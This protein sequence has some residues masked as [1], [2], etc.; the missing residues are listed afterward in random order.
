MARGKIRPH[1]AGRVDRGS[2]FRAP[3]PMSSQELG[4][5]SGPYIDPKT[6]KRVSPQKDDVVKERM[7]NYGIS[8]AEALGQINKT[9]ANHNPE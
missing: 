7:S 4:G 3:K 5:M 9:Q 2:F 8:R 6:G 1:G